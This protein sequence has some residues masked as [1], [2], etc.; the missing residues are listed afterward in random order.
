MTAA[1]FSEEFTQWFFDLPK[2]EALEKAY[3]ALEVHHTASNSEINRAFRSLSMIYHPDRR[4]GSEERFMEL[5]I[6]MA[7]IK[8]ARG[9]L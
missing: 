1:H 5:Q 4:S 9:Q 6:Y 8:A 2:T 7:I 3:N